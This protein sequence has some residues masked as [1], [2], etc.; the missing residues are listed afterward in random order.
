M[1]EDAR[2]PSRRIDLESIRFTF[3]RDTSEGQKAHVLSGER[4]I[5]DFFFPIP[6]CRV[7]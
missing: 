2:D 6:K 5:K 4:Q 1:Y 3:T 7:R